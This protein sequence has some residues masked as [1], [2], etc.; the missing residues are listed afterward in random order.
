[1]KP[2]R[3]RIVYTAGCTL[4]I[5]VSAFAGIVYYF[6]YR[7]QQGR[8]VVNH[9][10]NVERNVYSG[11]P[12]TAHGIEFEDVLIHHRSA[13]FLRG[14]HRATSTMG[15]RKSLRNRERKPSPK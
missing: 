10:V 1:M 14:I 8:L 15:Y 2:L 9:D 11:D 12:A 5:C 6:A 3:R 4:L 7:I 13:S